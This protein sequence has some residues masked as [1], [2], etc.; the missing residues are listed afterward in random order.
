M[1]MPICA[2]AAEPRPQRS[3]PP[4]HAKPEARSK[5]LPSPALKILPM[6]ARDIDLLDIAA[7]MV[8]N[9]NR[10][11]FLTGKAGTGKTTFLHG[12]AKSTHKNHLI[13]A[14]TGI[15]ALNAGGVTIHSQFLLPFGS[16]IPGERLENHAGG[17]FYT[18]HDLARRHPL[19][20][21]RKKVLRSIDLLIIDEVSMLRAD[22]LDAIDARLRSVKG[23]F[24]Q[25]FG[26]V[27]VL[28]IGDLYQLPPIVK[29]DEWHVLRHFYGSAHFF[30]SNALKHHGFAYVELEK[31][32]RQ[33]DDRFIALLNN[34][35]NN[36]CTQADLD[37]LNAHY[38]PGA[39][40]EDG[41][42][43]LTTHNRQAETINQ[44]ELESLPSDPISYH[45][46]VE[47]D[48]P[49][50]LFP[51]PARLDLKVGAQVM[52]VKN[53]TFEKR[54]YN[55][56]LARIT[57]LDAEG[58]TVLPQD[59]E[60]EL[61]IGMVVWE[62]KRYSINESSGGLEEEV[63]GTFSQYPI[64]TAWAITVH[65]SQGLTFDKAVIDVG[66][67]FAPGQVYVAL[68][69]LRSLDGLQLLRRLQPNVISSD[70]EVMR[71]SDSRKDQA[72]LPQVLREGQAS[73]LREALKSTFDFTDVQKQLQYILEKMGGSL[74]FEDAEMNIAVEGLLAKLRTEEENTRKFRGQIEH[75]LYHQDYPVLKAR[76]EKAEGYYL[77]FLKDCHLYL[78]I[79]IGEVEMLSRTKTYLNLLQE[80][81]QL[82][83]YQIGQLLKARHLTSCIANDENVSRNPAI[84]DKHKAM[85][86]ALYEK[87]RAHIIENPK[88]L[89]SKSGRKRKPASTAAGLPK[90]KLPKEKKPN[91]YLETKKLLDEGKTAQQIAETRGLALGTIESHFARLVS[92]GA[93]DIGQ[94]LSQDE[95]A[96]IRTCFDPKEKTNLGE[97]FERSKGKYS[98]GKLRMVQ[99]LIEME[100][101]QEET[102]K[103]E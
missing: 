24:K 56:K 12:L 96:A 36:T 60:K 90:S 22:L 59:E 8:N 69:R 103:K 28:M 83:H 79:H 31:I 72:P 62:N 84:A 55:G 10:H 66:Q 35:R 3:W 42:V 41:V 20:S 1:S 11:I 51:L 82:F 26:G 43:T 94:F 61:R 18:R 44:K 9:T 77:S 100:Q 81:E 2:S 19:N 65:K 37:A 17:A 99:A 53:D 68:S 13:V 7:R 67:A 5:V 71:F 92:D 54:Y 93:A 88:N 48:F 102:S 89:K 46:E 39:K 29:D 16:F 73:Y 23:N 57:K 80:A 27:Q 33:S 38:T 47:G 101:E 75:L 87:A 45:A 97:A 6:E 14:P 34:L 52:F 21:A 4:N 86:E 25:A 76:I 63:I 50:H 78:L 49:E 85:R 58:I 98:Y 74:D 70:A 30:E 91:T 15:A 64:K 32:F 95:I 40:A